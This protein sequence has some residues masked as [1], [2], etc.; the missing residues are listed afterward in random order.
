MG[1]VAKQSIQTTIF[2][3]IGVVIGYFNVLWLY[4]YA[5][6]ASELGTFRTIQDLGLLF[7]PF[8]QLG[9]GHGITRYFPKLE[10]NKSAFLSYSLMIAVAGFLLVSILFIGLRT[11]IIGLF[12]A[13]SPEVV[14]FLGV[15]LLIT[16]FALLNS[17]LDSY[18]RSYLKIAIPTFFRE[19]FLRL[20]TGCLVG[21]YLLK[22][23]SFPQ[24]MN[25]LVLVYGLALAG[26]LIYLIWLRVLTFDLN[27]KTFPK[28]FRSSFVQFSLITFLATAAS[29]LIMKIDSIMVSSMISLEANAIYTIAFSMALVIELPR[30]AISQVIMP[31]VADHFANEKLAEINV[32]YKQV[33][34]RQLYVCILLFIG[35]WA[36]IDAVY[37][38]IPNR[39]IYMT[40]K[41]VVFLIGLGKLFDV[42]FS[43][44]SEILVFSKFFRFNLILTIAMSALIILL[45]LILIPIFGI[46]GAAGASAIVMLLF[47][48]VKYL[49]LKIRLGLEPFSKETLKILGV[50]ILTFNSARFVTLDASPIENL[51][52]TSLVVLI[53][54]LTWS[55]LLRAGREE[56]LWIKEKI[57]KSGS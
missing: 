55:L 10:H 40:G 22:W 8:A 31:V 23:I 32:L 54:F 41:S 43:I 52:F 12:A 28:G 15:V 7:V 33:S 39:E 36:N 29:T 21:A 45:N 20:L 9:V 46:E 25:G 3:Y 53:L 57:K 50:G 30:R 16:L 44:N 6:D 18:S 13:N 51:I 14:D 1:K 47:N 17:I 5:M 4:P 19:V 38:F 48:L 42:A 56:W 37:S 26:V 2:S 11:Q 34:N 49:F 27:W 24:V 35:I